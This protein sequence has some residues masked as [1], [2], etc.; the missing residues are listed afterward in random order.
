MELDSLRNLYNKVLLAESIRESS[1]T[2]IYMSELGKSTKEIEV[3]ETSV[4]LNR[5]LAE[6]NQELTKKKDLINVVSSFNKIGTEVRGWYRNHALL[7]LL[8]ALSLSLLALLLVELNE[9][10]KKIAENL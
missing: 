1:G 8:V 9:I 4:E 5:L 6:I 3:F 2:T 7:G 10:L